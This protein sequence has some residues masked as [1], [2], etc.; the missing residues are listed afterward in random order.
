[1]VRPVSE[2]VWKWANGQDELS[3]AALVDFGIEDYSNQDALAEAVR[4]GATAE[5]LDKALGN[6]KK[7]GKLVKKYAPKFGEI[8]FR[9]SWD[10]IEGRA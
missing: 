6:G 10:I 9:T 2:R 7:I 3:P 5:E 4:G 8:E 1:M